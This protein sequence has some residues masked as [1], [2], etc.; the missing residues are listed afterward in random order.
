MAERFE[1]HKDSKHARSNYDV[2]WTDVPIFLKMTL[3]IETNNV[4]FREWRR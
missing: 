2:M 3:Q 4:G 1:F